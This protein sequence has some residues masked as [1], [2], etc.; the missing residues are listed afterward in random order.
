MA[1][2]QTTL[3][4]LAHV[5]IFHEP[6]RHLERLHVPVPPLREGELLVRVDACSICASD[7]HTAHGR[8]RQ[9]LPTILGHEVAG[10]VVA[11]GAGSPPVDLRGLVV[12][13][14][15][16]VTW[17]PCVSCGECDRCRQ[18]LPQKCR[19]LF[20][21]GHA[22]NDA[23]PL[24]GGFAD[25]VL[26]RRRTAIVRLPSRLPAAVAA[27]AG[28]VVAT[29]FSVLDS[30]GELAGRSVVVI[31][32][33]MLGLSIAGLAT[34]RGATS[35]TLIDPKC[36]RLDQAVTSGLVTNTVPWT[37]DSKPLESLLT[38]VLREDGADLV[39]EASGSA[40]GAAAAVHL[41][42]TAGRCVLAG[43]VAPVG[44]AVI[45]PE[46]VVRRQMTLCGVHN[47]RPTHLLDAVDYLAGP[48][49]AWVES[50][51]GPLLPLAAIDHALVIAATGSALRVV[52]VP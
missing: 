1:A 45:D 15:D 36:E 23:Y 47:Y 9:P 24:A 40:A 25:H 39:V 3:D 34:A 10:T 27:M 19:Y 20:K 35:V 37:A 26:L 12:G 8:R 29:A 21:Y 6:G 42:A 11:L 52:V 41:V 30:G 14:G 31:G 5:A 43:T 18:R 46:R 51:V 16:R 13:I 22:A 17:S 50:C 32:A 33:G 7:L 38:G 44:N 49:G 48:A 28:C 4:T 2:N